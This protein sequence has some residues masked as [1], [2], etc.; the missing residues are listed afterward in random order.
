MTAL[1]TAP[2]R[3]ILLDRRLLAVHDKPSAHQPR[4]CQGGGSNPLTYGRVTAAVFTRC[5]ALALSSELLTLCPLIMYRHELHG[6]A[7][8]NC[9]LPY[10]N[11]RFKASRELYRFFD[12]NKH[13]YA[14]ALRDVF[15]K[16][17]PRPLEAPLHGRP[18]SAEPQ[19]TVA[20][21]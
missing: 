16:S 14:K 3:A 9:W 5:S 8:E 19:S 6:D 1:M 17:P 18:A 10:A 21:I 4:S 20:D 2:Y 7:W 11:E 12:A 13:W 15:E